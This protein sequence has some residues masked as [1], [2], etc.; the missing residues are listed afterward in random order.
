LL[1]ARCTEANFPRFV[2]RLVKSLMLLA[3]VAS[4]SQL[5]CGIEFRPA[6]P[7]R[8]VPRRVA[9]RRQRGRYSGD[10]MDS[11]IFEPAASPRPARPAP[12]SM[13]SA[14]PWGTPRRR[15]PLRK[16]MT[17]PR[18]KLPGASRARGSEIVRKTSREREPTRWGWQ[19]RRSRV[20]TLPA[21]GSGTLITSDELSSEKPHVKEL[22]ATFGA[23]EGYDR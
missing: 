6:L 12:Q 1:R 2:K 13:T 14:R 3:P 22:F 7:L 18:L 21:I 17:G 11:G 5:D 15:A 23:Y 10:G 16:S 20:L 8:D 9:P 4:H 19:W